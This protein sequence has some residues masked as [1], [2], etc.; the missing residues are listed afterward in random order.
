MRRFG[1]EAGV[2]LGDAAVG[3]SAGEKESRT[4]TRISLAGSAHTRIRGR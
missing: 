1:A 4:R 2:S 3:C